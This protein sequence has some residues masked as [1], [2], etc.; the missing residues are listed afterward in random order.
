VHIEQLVCNSNTR[1][2]ISQRKRGNVKVN[3]LKF[4]Q[5]NDFQETKLVSSFHVDVFTFAHFSLSRNSVGSQEES[6]AEAEL[7]EVE[8]EEEGL[9]KVLKECYIALPHISESS[10]QILNLNGEP[11]LNLQAEQKTIKKTTFGKGADRIVSTK[12]EA[13]FLY[14]NII[15]FRGYVLQY[16]F[17]TIFFLLVL[18]TL[19]CVYG[20]W[21]IKPKLPILFCLSLPKLLIFYAYLLFS[22][23]QIKL[24]ALQA[25]IPLL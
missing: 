5:N 6:K 10:V 14:F 15:V 23:L 11:I 9:N 22:L 3:T 19:L 21:K 20:I 24:Q 1:L 13:V 8:N 16:V 2:I 18:K 25:L 4:Y 12:F 7:L 17:L